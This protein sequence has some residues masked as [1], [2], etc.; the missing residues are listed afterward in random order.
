MTT[1]S[2]TSSRRANVSRR[3]TTARGTSSDDPAERGKLHGVG[4]GKSPVGVLRSQAFYICRETLTK[5][6][7]SEK[8]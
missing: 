8:I 4:H 3:A 5:Q 7:K 1:I 6:A 2:A